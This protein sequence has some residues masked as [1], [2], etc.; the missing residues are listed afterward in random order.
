M[1]KFYIG[2]HLLVDLFTFVDEGCQVA[3][4]EFKQLT[5]HIEDIVAI[6]CGQM[7]G[8]QQRKYCRFVVH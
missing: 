8:E 5:E 7:P 1:Q 2:R 4:S 6:N 3:A